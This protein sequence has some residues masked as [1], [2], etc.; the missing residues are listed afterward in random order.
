[1]HRQGRTV[2][3]LSIRLP[4]G[5]KL[6]GKELALFQAA[7]ATL[8]TAIAATPLETRLASAN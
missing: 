4:T 1:M 3:P 6:K 7:L 8:K 2:N 5:R